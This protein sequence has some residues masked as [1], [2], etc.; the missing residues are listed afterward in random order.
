MGILIFKNAFSLSQLLLGFHNA[1]RTFNFVQIN[2]IFT[3]AYKINFSNNFAFP[4][5]K[6][7]ENDMSVYRVVL[8]ADLR[9]QPFNISVVLVYVSSPS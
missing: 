9:P 1:I 2:A 5:L 4:S 7:I 8:V 6:P 3:D